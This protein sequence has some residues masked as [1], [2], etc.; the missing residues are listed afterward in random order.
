[1]ATPWGLTSTYEG[2]TE[3]V[4][5]NPFDPL[6]LETRVHTATINGRQFIA[7]YDASLRRWLSTSPLGR[8]SELL[9]DGLGRPVSSRRGALL[10]TSF[11]YDA[12]GRL[13][14]I[15]RGTGVDERRIDFDYDEL[16][17]VATIT[18]P[19]LRQV[20]FGY[21]AANRV[22]SQTLPGGRTVL[23]GWDAKGNLTSLAP[24]GRPAH[25][26][27]YTPVDL[28][29]EYSPPGVG[30]G[31][32]ETT[33]EYDLDKKPTLITRPDEQTIALTYDH[34]DRLATV[35]SPRGTAT[36]DY[37]PAT[38]HVSSLTT[39]EGNS[40]SYTMDGPLVTATT[41]SGEINGSVER[42]YDNF[43]RLS[44]ISVNGANPVSYTY[45][46][47]GL[48]IQA[49][50]M[51]LTRD[52]ATGFLTGT[53]LG[54]VTTS[55]TYSPF[56]ELATM[57]AAVSG[58][59]IYTTTYTRDKL[60]RITTKVE[61]IEGVTRTYDYGYDAAGRLD[62]VT[63][64]GILEADYD[65]DLNG[66]RLSKTTPGGTETGTYDDQDRMLI[67]GGASY[68]YTANGEMLTKTA[69]AE[70]TSFGYDVF[71]NLLGVDLPDSTAIDYVVDAKNRRIGKKV[72]G[73]L[74]RAFLWENSLAP[75]AELDDTGTVVTRFV[76]ATRRNVPDY[77]LK[78]GSTFRILHDHLG[79]PRLAIDVA[80]GTVAHRLDTDDWG[81]VVADTG[82]G[83]MPFGFGGAL[84]DPDLQ[85]VR[86]GARDLSPGP[87]RW[88]SKDVRRFRGGSANLCEYSFSD[89][90]NFLD[91]DGKT[92][93]LAFTVVGG[94]AIL[95]VSTAILTSPG[96]QDWMH[97]T[98]RDIQDGVRNARDWWNGLPPLMPTEPTVV[99]PGEPIE[100]RGPRDYPASPGRRGPSPGRVCRPTPDR[101]FP[102]DSTEPVRSGQD[103]LDE[104]TANDL[105]EAGDNAPS[106]GEAI[107]GGG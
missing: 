2:I 58:S 57:S 56:G 49:G 6:S 82:P 3:A 48:L 23:F 71:G 17:R 94:V 98:G 28:A 44:S 51:S 37:D 14:S 40:L 30:Q 72:D 79:T 85:L 10:A 45:D 77:L 65:Y 63:I 47:D 104:A 105:W 91:Q 36:I 9:T 90:I 11:A 52:P 8:Q 25:G 41:W 1:M 16:G 21:D 86:L 75:S 27:S 4:L 106:P 60:G 80:S 87:G 13:E 35:T 31:P 81:V 68:T 24:P 42:T 29:E 26:F 69:G 7:T 32:P 78:D 46:D 99:E 62:T 107:H 12:R 70:V 84:A 5:S 39:P 97:D 88:A 73:V 33:Y 67:Y 103:L 74:D 66:N 15:S 95:L 43:F 83:W 89:P 22:T 54:V 92:A 19:L 50:A 61:M 34:A 96:Y 64:D 76:Y 101:P 20:T 93:A 38:G 59:P 102:E 100:Y 55:Y 18:D 53:T